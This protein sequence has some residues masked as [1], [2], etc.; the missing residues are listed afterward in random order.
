VDARQS[1]GIWTIP[2]S[3]TPTLV[4]G[5][6][7]LPLSM[8]AAT[9]ADDE[10]HRLLDLAVKQNVDIQS[11]DQYLFLAENQ[12][13]A[14][15]FGIRYAAFEQIVNRLTA[16]LQPYT[17]VEGEGS[18][19]T[20]FSSVAP[21]ADAS[22]GA[23]LS[24]DT[25]SDPPSDDAA[26]GYHASYTF[27]VNGPGDYTL[28]AAATP[29]GTAASP[30]TW[31]VDDGPASDAQDDPTVGGPYAGKFAWRDLGDLPLHGGKHTLTIQVTGRRLE[32]QRY[33]LALDAFCITRV[34]FLP[35]GPTQ[36]GV[37][38]WLPPATPDDKDK[39]H[40]K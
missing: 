7:Y 32:D 37:D 25:D 36:P 19:D 40:K 15:D 4:R 26:G 14:E 16:L 9:A 21:D 35:D 2:V 17:W 34:P 10:A 11:E 27:S 28:W 18:A 29:P 38:T 22:N 20:T 23:Y 12:T 39:K 3:A 33:V 13:H 8:D 24:L 5:I 6:P 31:S 1:H 30:F